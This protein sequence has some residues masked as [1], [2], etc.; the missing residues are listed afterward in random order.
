MNRGTGSGVMNG[1]LAYA[2]AM[3][4][5]ALPQA[6]L[7]QPSALSLVPLDPVEF[8]GAVTIGEPSGDTSAPEQWFMMG[9][10]LQVRNVNRAQLV[11]FL[12]PRHL[13]TG[14]AVIVAPGGAFLGLAF[15]AEGI[16]VARALNER[17]IAAFVLKYRLVD[18]PADLDTY[19]DGLR[20]VMSGGTA[21]FAPPEDT[22][23]YALADARAALRYLRGHAAELGIDPARIGMMGFSAGGFLTLSAGIE[24]P[25][26]E[27]PAFIAPIYPRMV[28]RPLD[29]DVPPMFLAIS[30]DDFLIADGSLGIVHSW[31][32]ACRP[33]EFHLY[34]DG[35]HGFG[36]GRRGTAPAGWIDDFARWLQVQS[37]PGSGEIVNFN[38][39]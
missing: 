31:L 39:R 11:P 14:D 26:D 19:A 21:S 35:G 12:P 33:V 8:D 34:N 9:G 24:L 18:T 37:Q 25:P 6:V 5:A 1:L 17:G 20:A 10:D 7:A 3:L 29:V 32:D 36:L 16:D 23:S 27:R 22:P 30:R 13:A 28:A 38:C 2:L 15:Q 4:L